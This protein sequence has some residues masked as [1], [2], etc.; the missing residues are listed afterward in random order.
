MSE[1]KLDPS[2]RGNPESSPR[3]TTLGL[4]IQATAM[5]VSG[6]IDKQREDRRK[7]GAEANASIGRDEEQQNAQRSR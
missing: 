5:K 7:G 3:F 1:K 4:K 6:I 2:T